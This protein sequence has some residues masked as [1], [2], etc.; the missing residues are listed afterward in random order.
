MVKRLERQKIEAAFRNMRDA[1]IKSFAFFIFGYPGETLRTMEQTTRVRDRAGSGFRELLSGRAVSRHGAPR[2]V[3]ARGAARPDAD[4]WS[5][6]G[7]L[8]LP[9]A[10]ATGWTK[11]V[12]MQA[13]NRAKRRFFLRPGYMARHLGDVARLAL[14]KQGIV[15][16]VLRAHGLGRAR[17]RAS[18]PEVSSSTTAERPAGAAKPRW[19][20]RAERY[21][22]T[23]EL[24]RAR[25]AIASAAS[26]AASA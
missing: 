24:R 4:D 5:Q 15:W 11:A 20:R 14:T 26:A 10:A 19:R 6:D 8:V 21:R 17:R 18:A 23:L 25:P 2:Q 9:A 22:A 16:Q 12:V 13:I 1:G 7:V 3:R